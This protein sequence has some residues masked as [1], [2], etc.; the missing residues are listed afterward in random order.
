VIHVQVE[1]F[2]L[3]ATKTHQRAISV[4]RDGISPKMNKEAA[5][6]AF[7]GP[8]TMN[9]ASTSAKTAPR[10]STPTSRSKPHARAAALARHRLQ[11]VRVASLVWLERQGHHVHHAQAESFVLA[12]TM[13]RQHVISVRKDGISL[14]MGRAVAS[15]AFQ[16]PSTMSLV[17]S[18]AK[19]VP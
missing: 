18:S 1:S 8:L 2:V 4:Q 16:G 5:S 9:L 10:T 11:E 14:T 7:Q 19:T 3:A 15:R 17:W 12:A 13:T 6:L